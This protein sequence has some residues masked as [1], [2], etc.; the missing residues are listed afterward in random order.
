MLQRV[1]LILLLSATLIQAEDW[2]QFLGIHRN[3]ESG[4]TGLL[5]SMPKDG[6]GVVWKKTVGTGYSAP[7]VA[8]G[9]LVLH[10]RV[11]NLEVVECLS[12]ESG[13]RLWRH[14][15]ACRYQDPFGYNN[16]PRCSPLLT[17][18]RC[19]T[20]GVE[21]VLKCLDLE[22]GKVLWERDTQKE[23]KVP[24]AFFGVGSTPLLEKDSLIVMVG[25][26]PNATMVSLDARTG[27]TQWEAVGQKTWEGTA[28]LGW[29]GE[30]P[31]RWDGYEKL[32]S[33]ASPIAATLHGKR[34]LLCFVR[35]GMVS[36]S[37]EDGSVRF[38]RWFRPRVN[39][40]VNAMTPIVIDNQLFFSTAYYA[41]GSVLMEIQPDGSAKEVWSTYERQKKDRR[42]PPVMEMHWA[43][44]VYHDGHIYGFSGR[45][46]PD[47]EFRCV[48]FKT[49]ELKWSRHERWAK[50]SSKQPNVFGRGSL[51]KADGRMYGLGEGGLLGIFE[52]N[53]SKPEEVGRWQVPELHYPCWAGPVLSDK[54]LYL[55]S[56]DR[57]I[58]LDLEER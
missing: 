34:H 26:Q 42:H 52:F 18:K 37:P 44:P 56:E 47:A 19:Y 50:Y 22:T 4:E 46:E 12:K 32:A 15:Y 31:V 1:V 39:E 49:G 13:E 17:D 20:Y 36:I 3:A 21:G 41:D 6:P 16:G 43:T 38:K 10:H 54:R 27:K 55:R 2:P 29:P 57:L 28:K 40:S 51:I 45:N 24:S 11:A 35:Q 5:T 53:S 30:P 7:S 33:Y 25:G 9:K 14:D 58:C 23:W 8:A 48:E